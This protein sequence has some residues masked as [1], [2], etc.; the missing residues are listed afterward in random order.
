MLS[1]PKVCIPI[2]PVYWVVCLPFLR[3]CCPWHYWK[4]GVCRLDGLQYSILQVPYLVC[5]QYQGCRGS[6]LLFKS[7]G[8]NCLEIC[9]NL[10]FSHC[11]TLKKPSQSLIIQ[12]ASSSP[13]RRSGSY[14]NLIKSIYPSI[15]SPVWKSRLRCRLEGVLFLNYFLDIV[16]IIEVY[17]TLPCLV[18]SQIRSGVQTLALKWL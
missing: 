10:V 3:W 4:W 8:I 5:I 1:T 16:I 13:H 15:I 2:V 11:E 18:L 14:S 7:T 17:N 12:S 6:L 9:E